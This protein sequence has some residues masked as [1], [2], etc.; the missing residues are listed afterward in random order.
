MAR[1]AGVSASTVSRILNGS[2]KVAA[3]KRQAVE[4]AIQELNFRPNLMAQYL[5][6]GQSMTLGVLT[7]HVESPF[8]NEMLRGVEHTLQGMEYVPLIVSGHWNAEEEVERLRL[9]VAR[10]VDGLIILTGH[11]NQ[12]T[13]LEF[14]QQIPIVATGHNIMTERVHS[15]SINNRLGGYMATRYLL[16]L[17]HRDIA[18][19]VGLPDHNDAIERH[20]GY[21]QALVSAGI[22]YDPS[23]VIQGDFAEVGGLNAVKKLV[24]SGRKFSAIFCANDQTCYGA[25]LGLKQ[26]GL[27]VPEDVS[28]IGFD[29]LPFSTFSNPP[30]TT[31][32]QPIYEMGVKMVKTL[33]GLIENTELNSDELPELSIVVRDTTLPYKG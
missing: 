2:A 11:V 20:H 19:I 32:R 30:L 14:S 10:R 12:Q 23:L 16:D 26:C 5:K 33:L 18:H 25:I 22:E 24:E 1:R 29:D 3:D 17:G 7:Q 4:D 15:F 31:V 21:R 8:S 9:L 6:T 28:L 13:L 27:R